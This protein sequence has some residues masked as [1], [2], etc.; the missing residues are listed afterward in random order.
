ME[1]D[2]AIELL[3]CANVDI[4]VVPDEHLA[5]VYGAIR[6]GNSGILNQLVFRD[7]RRLIHDMRV[8]NEVGLVYFVQL[9]D[10]VMLNVIEDGNGFL[11]R[12]FDFQFV[13]SLLLVLVSCAVLTHVRKQC[14]NKGL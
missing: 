6:Y 2:V 5:K 4:V 10:G 12:L 13:L 9:F 3:L 8:V 7:M 14:L 1:D 11:I